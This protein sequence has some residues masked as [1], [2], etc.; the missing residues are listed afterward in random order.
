MMKLSS[1]FTVIMVI[2]PIYLI[3]RWTSICLELWFNFGIPPIAV[4]PSEG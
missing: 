4:L 2:C 3:L 1:Y